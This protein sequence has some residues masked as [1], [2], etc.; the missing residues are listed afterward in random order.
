MDK[1]YDTRPIHAGFEERGCRPII[2]LKETVGVKRGE[3]RS[4]ECEHGTWTLA[5]ADF[6]NKRTK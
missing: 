2:P 3:H 6:K 4:P 1:G 5:G